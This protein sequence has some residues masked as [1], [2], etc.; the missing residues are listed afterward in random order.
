MGRFPSIQAPV[1]LQPLLRSLSLA[2]EPLNAIILYRSRQSNRD[3]SHI[4][5]LPYHDL[6]NIG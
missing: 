4:L 2:Q 3:A 6:G 1:L 5:P